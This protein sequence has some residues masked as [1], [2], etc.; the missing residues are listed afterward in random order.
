[1]WNLSP[2]SHLTSKCAS[3]EQTHW[4]GRNGLCAVSSPGARLSVSDRGCSLPSDP[5]IAL[6]WSSPF[7]QNILMW[8][9]G[10]YMRWNSLRPPQA[11]LSQLGSFLAWGENVRGSKGSSRKEE[12][13]F[14]SSCKW[15]YCGWI[16]HP[17]IGIRKLL[18]Y[19]GWCCKTAKFILFF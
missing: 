16:L 2:F 12:N 19:P 14:N 4:L 15:G 9:E 10:R 13:N 7:A 1:M 6:W 11:L 17:H 3:W 18:T 8:V 5:G